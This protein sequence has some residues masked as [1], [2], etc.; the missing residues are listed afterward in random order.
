MQARTKRKPLS[1]RPLGDVVILVFLSLVVLAVFVFS[2]T[3]APA[4]AAV[5]KPKQQREVIALPALKGEA[6][7][8]V[9]FSEEALLSAPQIDKSWRSGDPKGA[10]NVTEDDVWIR[11][12]EKPD[13]KDKPEKEPGHDNRDLIGQPFVSPDSRFVALQTYAGPASIVWLIDMEDRKKPTMTRLTAEGFGRFLGWHPDSRHALYLA[14]DEY[15]IDPGLWIVD[16]SDDTHERI[17]INDLVAPQGLTAAAFSPDGSWVAYAVHGG[18]GTGS[19]V[20]LWERNQGSRTVWKDSLTVVGSLAFSP[21]GQRLAFSNL[22]DSPVPFAEAGLWTVDLASNKAEFLTT[23]DGG[24]GQKPLWSSD[25]AKLYFV[26]RDNPNDARADYDSSAL[27]SSIRAIDVKSKKETELA[28]S[29]G[30]RQI[31]LSLTPNGDLM[32]AS[33]RDG[34]SEIW[35]V[36]ES[37]RM[38]KVTVDGSPKRHPLFIA[39]TK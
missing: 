18:M 5:I 22:L 37:G 6:N 11:F 17:E 34:S 21:D 28:S 8:L 15:V 31:D 23:M 32:F 2:R 16:V 7:L 25:S 10:V 13:K 9:A 30:S 3:Q 38:Q 4:Q 24:H 26:K 35:S 1:N 19:E 14:F 33:N 12:G 36:N 39:S 29:N 27:V 20:R